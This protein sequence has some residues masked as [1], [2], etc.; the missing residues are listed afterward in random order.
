MWR[1]TISDVGVRP[2]GGTDMGEQKR[3][4]FIQDYNP[5]Y[6]YKEISLI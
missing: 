4:S 6:K 1:Y 2:S 5:T 3:T